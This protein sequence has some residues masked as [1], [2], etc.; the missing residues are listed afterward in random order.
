ML[1]DRDHYV[2]LG[3]TR[4]ASLDEIRGA[5]RK[6]ARATHPDLNPGDASALEQFKRVQLAY[7]VLGDPHRRAAYDSPRYDVP[8][9][10]VVMS[11]TPRAGARPG[12]SR[13]QPEPPISLARE[14]GETFAAI[15]VVARRSGFSRRVDRLIRYLERL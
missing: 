6:A 3:L 11:G 2:V 5:Y 8:G 10:D 4:A 12:A 1:T 14:L 13:R 7:E 15:R 9:R